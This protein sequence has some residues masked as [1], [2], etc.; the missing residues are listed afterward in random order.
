VIAAEPQIGQVS[1]DS[2]WVPTPEVLI[3]RMLQLA[4]TTKDDVVLDLGSGDGRIP[5]YAAKHFGARG[6][7]VELEEN[8]VRLAERK[9]EEAGVSHRVRFIRQDLFQADL[10]EATVLALYTSPGVMTRLKPRLL[11]L[12]PGTR[13]VS[14]Q[15]TLE[16]W[17][18]DESVRAEGRTGHLWVVPA[19]VAGTWRVS[20][21]GEDFVVRI[22]QRYQALETEGERDGAPL[23]VIGG[24]MRGT[25]IRFTSFERDGD[26]RHFEGRL[27]DGRLA[28]ES[29]G[30][31]VEPRPWSAVRAD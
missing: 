31:G 5:I 21:R 3:R 6:I 19:S 7:G 9:A 13:V 14:H 11:G 18:P 26:V 24:R 23:H 15:F 10:A 4:D 27:Q 28:G 20:I 30:P 25:G 17:E 8:L 12:R 1:K 22:A 29:R 16:D 2:V